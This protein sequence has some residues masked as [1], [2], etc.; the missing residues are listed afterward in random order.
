M[1]KVDFYVQQL[2]RY[3]A[4]SIELGSGQKVKFRLPEGD[5]ETSKAIDHA[6]VAALVQEVAPAPALEAIRTS[7][8]AQFVHKSSEGVDVQ[9]FVDGQNPGAWT[10][11]IARL[12]SPGIGL[13]DDLGPRLAPPA[14]APAPAA[15]PVPAAAPAPR[16][17]AP[18]AAVAPAPAPAGPPPA[19]TGS[20]SKHE[21]AAKGMR[22]ELAPGEPKINRYLRLMKMVDASDLHLSCGVVPMVRRHGEMV[23]LED[24]PPMTDEEMRALVA[25]IIP[26]RSRK[27]FE[28]TNDADFAHAIPGLSRFRANVFADRRGTGAVFRQ[29]P[30]T[31]VSAEK[32]GIP[33]K[34]KDLCWLSKGLVLV[35]GP[36]GS[37][38]STTLAALID[39]INENRSDHIITIEDPVE[40]VHENKN[41]L[42]NQ[43]EIG[44]HTRSF[45]SALRA[46]LREDPDIVLVGEMRDLETIS[47]AIETAETGHLVFGTLHTT[48]AISTVDRIIDQFPPEQQAQIRVM[49]SESLRGV[50]AQVLC[51][52]KGG[53][54][55]AAYEILI[56]NAACANLIREGKTFQLKSVMQTGR[57]LGMQTMNDHLV[58]HVKKGLVEPQ[59]A[60][61]KSND[62]IL[63]KE[64]LAREGHKIELPQE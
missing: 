23:P 8:R 38:K 46:A 42:V 2:V 4:T 5:R 50:I 26:E 17:A 1:L 6:L 39:F 47:I 29:I 22:V 30:F 27:E 21:P 10:V 18:V 57:N 9:I 59:E 55:V 52:K 53:G 15:I 37:G 28:E 19:P 34:V 61:I 62:K 56:S 33:Q 20:T 45:K 44:T 49:L 7:G 11:R 14:P 51:K 31:I 64:A 32:L 63:M 25:E 24:R 3:N 16:A 54:R 58:E 48:S 60:Y 43:R 40:F 12:A 36:T 35:T 13:A 41:C